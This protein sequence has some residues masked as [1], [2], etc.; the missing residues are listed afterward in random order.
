MQPSESLYDQKPEEPPAPVPST[1]NNN[2]S[3]RPSL[4][5][6]FEYVDNVQ[7]SELDSGGSNVYNH[8]SAPKSSNFFADFGMDS[9]FP[10]KFGSNTSKVQVSAMPFSCAL[11]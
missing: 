5:S 8:A 6:R 2:V 7:S 1:T 9:G 4:T 10:K 11:V 3:A